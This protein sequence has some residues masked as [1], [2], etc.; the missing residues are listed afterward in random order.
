MTCAL[1]DKTSGEFGGALVHLSVARHD[2]EPQGVSVVMGV[3][4]VGDRCTSRFIGCLK[5]PGSTTF[6]GDS[7]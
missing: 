2:D 3:I 6:F 5:N 1:V 4:F 7:S